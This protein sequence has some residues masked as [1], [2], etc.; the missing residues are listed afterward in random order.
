[1]AD[2]DPGHTHASPPSLAAPYD[3]RSAH[4]TT[5]F[6]ED[7]TPVESPD[8]LPL[9][10]L[11]RCFQNAMAP[12]ADYWNVVGMGLGGTWPLSLDNY[13]SQNTFGELITHA[14]DLIT[15]LLEDSPE[16]P[17]APS[18]VDRIRQRLR[19]GAS[20]A[21]SEAQGFPAV[22]IPFLAPGN[23]YL[24]NDDALLATLLC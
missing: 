18:T 9:A 16:C 19:A 7:P 15:I 8:I 20:E 24:R 3:L 6:V 12:L 2:P 1:M 5:D 22:R 14:E 17:A 21:A 13:I 23:V 4:P 10:A 11:P